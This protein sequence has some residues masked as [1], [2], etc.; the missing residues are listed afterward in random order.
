MKPWRNRFAL[1]SLAGLLIA[2]PPVISSYAPFPPRWSL[3]GDPDIVMPFRMLHGVMVVSMSLN[4][5]PGNFIIDT[6]ALTTLLNASVVD[7][8]ALKT[9]PANVT[10]RSFVG[11]IAIVRAVPQTTIFG[12]GFQINGG[13]MVLNLDDLQDSIG[14]PLT[15]IIGSDTLTARP[16]IVDYQAG[17][18]TIFDPGN[19]PRVEK[20][21]E[22]PLESPSSGGEKF[23]GPV[24]GAHLELPNGK[25]VRL[26]LE[27]DTGSTNGLTLH[28]PF[29]KKYGL[30]PADL[31]NPVQQTAA[32]GKYGL[33][34]TSV[35]ALFLGRQKIANP[36]TLCVLNAVGVAGSTEADGEIGYKILSRFRIF[37]D[38]PQH[39]AAF[40]PY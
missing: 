10:L 31:K 2:A 18:V 35:P 9:I 24:I 8:E 4:G 5:K 40:E 19:L 6:G 38:A 25:L 29:A 37:I 32:G 39:F 22:T 1:F 28:A 13:A 21:S 14:I 12:Y 7:A 33:A 30:L 15:G 11:N 17:K 26:N 34:R 16:I 3:F 36:E 27:I 20:L 23:G